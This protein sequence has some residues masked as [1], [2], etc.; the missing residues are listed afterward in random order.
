MPQGASFYDEEREEYV[1]IQG[2]AIISTYDQFFADQHDIKDMLTSY[3]LSADVVV[4]PKD[5]D[6]CSME[7]EAS[8]YYNQSRF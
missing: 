1:S 2:R 6:Q 5:E 7:D 8:Q 3:I 4:N